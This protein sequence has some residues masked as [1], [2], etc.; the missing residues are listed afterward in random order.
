MQVGAVNSYLTSLYTQKS[1][2]LAVSGTTDTSSLSSIISASATTSSSSST[3][4]Q[5]RA[6]EQQTGMRGLS[7]LGASLTSGLLSPDTRAQLHQQLVT[8][9]ADGTPHYL[10]GQQDLAQMID[11]SV[12]GGAASASAG[13]S[14]VHLTDDD[15]T[16]IRKATGYNLVTSGD[17]WTLVDD[18]GNAPPEGTDTKSMFT[19]IDQIDMD[20]E[21]GTLTGSVTKD[22]IEKLFAR[23]Q[24]A[25]APYDED[26]QKKVLSLFGSDD[27]STS[28]SNAQ[29]ATDT[30][31]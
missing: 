30:S 2:S 6:F 29:K 19:L 9:S 13:T 8:P 31:D 22:Y 12:A 18:N 20:R 11:R 21:H 27:Q 26:F 24:Q 1:R 14:S 28:E 23:A 7:H 17:E 3:A 16:F 4:Q 25:G 5:V 10:T 15:F